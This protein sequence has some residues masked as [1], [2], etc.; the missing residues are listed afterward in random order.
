[1]YDLHG[2]MLDPIASGSFDVI[3]ASKIVVLRPYLMG[4]SMPV[5]GSWLSYA[6]QLFDVSAVAQNV[7]M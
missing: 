4:K 5:A 7:A 2:I 3:V 1:M 6:Q